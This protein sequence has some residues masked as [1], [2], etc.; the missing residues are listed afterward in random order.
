M[1]HLAGAMHK[2]DYEF[3]LPF[4]KK[5]NVLKANLQMNFDEIFKN[6]EIYSLANDGMGTDSITDPVTTKLFGNMG[7]IFTLTEIKE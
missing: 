6:P 1:F 2:Q 4:E 7:D 5:D 3:S